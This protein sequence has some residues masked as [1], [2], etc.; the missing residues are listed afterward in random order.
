MCCGS[1]RSALMSASASTPQPRVATP[2]PAPVAARPIL[3]P[4]EVDVTRAAA[5]AP[6]GLFSRSASPLNVSPTP[7]ARR[8]GLTS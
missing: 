1:K 7:P 5:F 4:Q 3:A 2:T 6:S 8:W